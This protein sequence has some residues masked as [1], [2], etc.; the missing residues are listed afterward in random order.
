MGRSSVG[1][2]GAVIVMLFASVACS[3][4]PSVS[5][6]A[7]SP[8]GAATPEPSP[9]VA[10]AP[11]ASARA[12][13]DPTPSIDRARPVYADFD[14]A[15]FSDSTN[16][17]NA[18]LPLQPGRRWITDGVTLEGGERIPHQ[19]IFTVTDLTKVISGVKTVVVWV[20]D[21]TDG[22]LVEREIAFYGQDDDGA[23]WYFGEYPEELEDGVVV[24][25]PTW[26][27]GLE[28]ARPGIKMFADPTTQLQT[29]YQGWGPGV[30]WS[31]FGRLDKAGLEDCVSSGCYRDVIR[32]AESSLGEEGIFQL[33]SYA[34]GVGEVR[35]GWRGEAESREE[36]E[37]KATTL[38][39]GSKLAAIRKMALELEEH[40]YQTSP[41]VYGKTEPMK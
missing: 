26:I 21:I 37:L 28:D 27:A 12:T 1:A 32:F 38:W 2:M 39:G 6:A 10:A 22:V 20:E 31:D 15:R 16:I 41:Q 14:P 9:T 5:Q 33:K 4:P 24:K 8:P 17:T 7:A 30:E 34:K 40:A 18:W 23:V 13:V 3:N 11:S 19:I 25:A 35:T 29:Y 36:L